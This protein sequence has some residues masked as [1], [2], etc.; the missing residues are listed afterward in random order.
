MQNSEP[1]VMTFSGHDPSGG[2]GLQA[3]IEAL[4]SVGCRAATV[5]TALTVQ[6]TVN[7]RRVLPLDPD[8]VA[9]QARTVLDD[10][11]VAAFKIGL[12]G[13]TAVAAAIAGVLR[14][15]P[16]VPVVLDPVLAAGGGAALAD[17]ALLTAIRDLLARVTLATPNG[18]EARRLAG[19]PA[20]GLAVCARTLIGH[21]CRW[22]LVTG[23]H[24]PDS[25]V[26]NRL[27]DAEGLQDS[28]TWP[29]LE[30]TY[31]GSGCT[32]AA[33]AAGLLA[34]GLTVREAVQGAQ[35]YTWHALNHGYRPGR[36]QHLPQRF[37]WAAPGR[38]RGAAP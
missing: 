8:L 28:T 30:A 11:P 20:A 15:H 18:V 14:E 9:D 24:E 33:A 16:R 29:R 6:D 4:A 25:G 23:G 32:L 5:A 7:V 37:Y 2:A 22:V 13:N 1:V 17:D 10:L 34:R 27:F 38:A 36:G 21:G 26:I 12:L 31:H 19:D 35:E 3:D